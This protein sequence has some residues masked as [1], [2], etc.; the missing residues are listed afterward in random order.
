MDPW[1]RSGRESKFCSTVRSSQPSCYKDFSFSLGDYSFDV[2]NSGQVGKIAARCVPENDISVK[3]G[4]SSD[5]PLEWCLPE[6][7]VWHV[8]VLTGKELYWPLE[9]MQE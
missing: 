7:V 5:E 3:K 4:Q 8:L 9:I 2:S 6:A 1:S